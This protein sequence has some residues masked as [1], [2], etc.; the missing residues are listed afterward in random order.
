MQVVRRQLQ[1]ALLL[2]L[3]Q[4]AQLLALLLLALVLCPLL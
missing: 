2:G 4:R 3:S 1:Q